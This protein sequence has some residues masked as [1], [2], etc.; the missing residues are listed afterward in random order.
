[1]PGDI[2]LLPPHSTIV[3]T[4]GSQPATMP[5]TSAQQRAHGLGS[6]RRA[7][8]QYAVLVRIACAGA[9]ARWSWWFLSRSCNAAAM[10]LIS[11]L[12]LLAAAVIAFPSAFL[13]FFLCPHPAPHTPPPRAA[14]G[15]RTCSPA[16]SSSYFGRPFPRAPMVIL[17][18]Y[19]RFCLR[20]RPRQSCQ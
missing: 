7:R 6:K 5:S 19:G 4:S 2:L 14:S 18:A 13:H 8:P 9:S 3:L 12:D 16:G 17:C 11:L 20:I 10:Q 15:P 1:M